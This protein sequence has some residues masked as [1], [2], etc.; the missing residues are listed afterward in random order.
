WFLNLCRRMM[1]LQTASLLCLI[2][3]FMIT[4]A[5]G[6]IW[7]V[8]YSQEHLCA[9]NGSTVFMNGSCQDQEGYT[10][11]E[12]F[13]YI[14][15]V[16]GE[17][18]RNLR[19]ES[20]YSGRVEYLGDKQI[21]SSLRLSD[22]KKTD[23]KKY[24]L[25]IISNK[26]KWADTTGVTLT[27]TDL[28]L[29]APAEVTEGQSAVLT[30]K[31]TCN[32]TDPTFI[33]YKN[34]RDLTTNTTKSNEVHLQPVSSEDA[35]SYSC[36]VRG[37]ERL[38]SPAR[39][40]RVRY[41]PKNVSVSIS[42]SGEIV[43]DSSVT[44]TCSSDA[45]PPVEIYT[46]F[47]GTT[48]VGEGKIYTISNITS[49][50]SGEEY[51]CKCSNKVG[52]QN[53]SSVTL[54]V[55]YPP[56][57]VSVSISPSLEI[58]E[59]SSVTLTCSSDANPPVENYTWFKEMTS[60][61]E[62]K[63]Y[64]TSKITS[65][66]SGEYKCKCSNK[67]GHQNSSSVTLNVL[68]P[69]KNVS[70][71]ISPP[72]EIVEGSSVTL[73]CS[74]DANPPVVNYTW[75]KEMTSVGEGKIYT[76]SNITSE[77]SGEEYKCKCSNEV[78]HHNSSSV[79]LNVLYSPKNV[80]VS[81]SP[82]GEILEGSSVILTCS[83]D[84]NPPVEIY[85]WFKVNE[86]SAVGSGQSYRAL[87]SGQYYCQAQN[88]HGS[89][90]SAAVPVT[91]NWF[92][93]IVVYAGFGVLVF[94]CICLIITCFLVRKKKRIDSVADQSLKQDDFSTNIVETNPID[95]PSDSDSSEQD[96]VLYASIVHKKTTDSSP[97]VKASA[98]EE[99]EVQYA[100]VRF[101]HTGADY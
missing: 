99:D 45:N 26:D 53:S 41:S 17:M 23:E 59:G 64:T 30:C 1:F 66:D 10:V 87:Q 84:A 83:S 8:T 76:I 49:E 11:T 56:K 92:Q 46:W 86:S 69:P 34:S 61:G 55:L 14:N 3:L 98:S 90:R 6:N 5:F 37:Y 13:W 44:L 88:K 51:K 2:S 40:L 50:D 38:P 78:G 39:T 29:I 19:N 15:R 80:S 93:R 7:T 18:P 58:V 25:R 82:S 68:Y 4:G 35:G 47:K 81:I 33:W 75:F 71:S 62:E 20:G 70:V 42:P 43:E 60:V 77:D 27:V 72:L 36:A 63:V 12:T 31:T 16:D 79:T 95:R 100:S 54:N 85:T 21:H 89:D 52:H 9:L 28:Q 73:T 57:N 67:V 101:T 94:V 22:V 48:S 96:E 24:Y 65:E 32:L 97:A 74:S 91:L